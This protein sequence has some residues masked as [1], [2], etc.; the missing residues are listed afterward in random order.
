MRTRFLLALALAGAV[1]LPA[2][3][4]PL[5]DLL[6]PAD[7]ESLGLKIAKYFEAKQNNK[8]IDKAKEDI[9]K[10][11]E[12]LRKK[13]KGREPLA[14]CGDLGKALWQSFDYKNAKG[15]A[16]GKIKSVTF[17][18]PYYGEK[19]Q[20]T[21]AIWVP[22][23]YDPRRPY[24][25]ILCIPEKG[26]KPEQHIGEKWTDKDTRENA[27]IVA[28]PM[29]EDVKQWTETGTSQQ[30]GGFSN[31]MLTLKQIRASYAVDYDR[32]YI[33]GR[34]EGVAAALALAARAPDRFAGVIGRSG[35]LD[36]AGPGV[37]NFKNLPTFFGGAGANATAFGEK[38]TKAEYGNCTIKA[39]ASDADVWTWMRDHPRVANPLEVVLYPGRPTP[40]KAYWVEVP[41]SDYK[42]PEFVKAKVDKASNLITIDA[43]DG[44]T[45]VKL[46]LNDD[47]VDLD[48]EVKVVCNG[49]EHV[50]KLPRNL[51]ATMDWM[52]GAINEPGRVFT[53]SRDYDVLPK[54]KPKDEKPKEEKKDEKKEEKKDPK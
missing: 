5:E 50:D 24:T 35:D 9:S 19:A 27:L 54:P 47:L 1:A 32:V 52:Y 10:E 41:Q 36:A 31:L 26:S 38:C 53:T 15:I 12:G 23:K 46:Y 14:L 45:K 28:V 40:N 18:E 44:I 16:A 37:E 8:G 21:Y 2:L 29:P 6:K 4:G 43:S 49:A 48:K 42:E 51:W 22:T 13:A 30:P 39:E 3:A 33:A 25:L 34:G 11:L 20:L 17:K 7:H